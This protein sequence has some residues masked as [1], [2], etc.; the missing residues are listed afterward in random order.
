MRTAV[1]KAASR[2]SA[3]IVELPVHGRARI[4]EDSDQARQG[5][6]LAAAVSELTG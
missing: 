4:N 6:V 1:E 2:A 3:G 5:E